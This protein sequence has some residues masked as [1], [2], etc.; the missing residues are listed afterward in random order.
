MED[1]TGRFHIGVAFLKQ[2]SNIGNIETALTTESAP[3]PLSLSPPSTGLESLHP[4]ILDYLNPPPPP[5]ETVCMLDPTPETDNELVEAKPI[6]NNR[7][8]ASY[9]TE[10]P[11]NSTDDIVAPAEEKTNKVVLQI[12]RIAAAEL[13]KYCEKCDISVTSED[14]MRLHLSGAKH[15]KKLRQLGEPPYT[16]SVATL[17]Q[18]I[19][20]EVQTQRPKNVHVLDGGNQDYS[21]FRTPSGNY[22]CQVCDLSVKSEVTLANHFAS[23]RHMKTAK[24]KHLNPTVSD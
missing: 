6:I 23:K 13:G 17:S 3:P 4:P 18:C 14:H 16:E 22:Y 7:G 11:S 10:T 19:S 5:G 24:R 15:N 1:P 9:S 8:E 20:N 12:P 2:E 21:V